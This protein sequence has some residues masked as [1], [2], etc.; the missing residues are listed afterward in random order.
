MYFYK[1]SFGGNVE[2]HPLS[3]Y[4]KRP[5]ILPRIAGSLLEEFCLG[6]ILLGKWKKFKR[7]RSLI[8]SRKG[9]K[10]GKGIRHERYSINS[11]QH[12]R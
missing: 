3:V 7:K 4:F 11:L 2:D 9:W 1:R 10:V 5:A 12:C 8:S 6:E